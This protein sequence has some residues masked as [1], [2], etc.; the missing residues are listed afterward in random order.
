MTK[1]LESNIKYYELYML[2]LSVFNR[3]NLIIRTLNLKT[4]PKD[5]GLYYFGLDLF[6]MLDDNLE[7]VLF[8]TIRYGS[9][10]A[11]VIMASNSI[12]TKKK[13]FVLEALTKVTNE[14]KA[15]ASNQIISPRYSAVWHEFDIV[16]QIPIYIYAKLK[17]ILQTPKQAAKF[18]LFL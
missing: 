16:F 7:I 8:V 1:I 11:N 17:F 13:L 5:I 6:C 10:P 18:M 4:Y 2:R 12:A 14:G 9:V 3:K 15:S